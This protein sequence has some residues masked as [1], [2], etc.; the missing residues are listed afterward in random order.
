MKF[1]INNDLDNTKG[2]DNVKSKKWYQ[3]K[4]I[5]TCIAALVTAAGAYLSGDITS[6]ELVKYLFEG[7]AAIFIRNAI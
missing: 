7:F 2:G 3:S 5:W 1:E 6:G 4:A